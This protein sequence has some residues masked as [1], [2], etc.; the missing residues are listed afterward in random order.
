MSLQQQYEKVLR[1]PRRMTEIY[2]TA[3]CLSFLSW[4]R[5]CY[6]STVAGVAMMTEGA[7]TFAQSAGLGALMVATMNLVWGTGCHVTN[8]V[9]LR[10]VSGMSSVTLFFHVAGSSLHCVLWAFVLLCY[11]GF[12]DETG[13]LPRDDKTKQQ[14]DVDSEKRKRGLIDGSRTV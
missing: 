14:V 1:H 2:A 7:S 6:I 13:G 4:C 11:I 12:L 10:N 9:R 5:N 3:G 8:L